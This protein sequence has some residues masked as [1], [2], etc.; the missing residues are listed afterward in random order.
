VLGS[1]AAHRSL[2]VVD[3]FAPEARH[4]RAAFDARHADPRTAR[5]DRFVWDGCK[6]SRVTRPPVFERE[7]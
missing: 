4:R 3:R 6:P 5:P 1:P 2:L 7:G